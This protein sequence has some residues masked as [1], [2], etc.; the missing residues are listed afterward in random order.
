MRKNFLEP[1]AFSDK[2]YFENLRTGNFFAIHI[3][4]NAISF[5][6]DVDIKIL[7]EFKDSFG[8]FCPGF[9]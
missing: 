9:P 1:E 2:Q 6:I 3:S 5:L 7:L 4:Y 8:K